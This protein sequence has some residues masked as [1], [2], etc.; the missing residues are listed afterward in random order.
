MFTWSIVH[1]CMLNNCM[2]SMFVVCAVCPLTVSALQDCVMLSLGQEFRRLGQ[3][4]STLMSALAS[5]WHSSL[6]GTWSWS[7]LLVSDWVRGCGC[8]EGFLPPSL[9]LCFSKN[10]KNCNMVAA[11]YFI[12]FQS[13]V[14]ILSPSILLCWA[15][16]I[17]GDWMIWEPFVTRTIT[18]HMN[19][20]HTVYIYLFSG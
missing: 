20:N 14:I 19:C 11:L 4:T 12:E 6:G 2:H 18:L 7:M 9:L 10:P 15:V 13:V 17:W 5:L 8:H 3:H 16:I 1:I